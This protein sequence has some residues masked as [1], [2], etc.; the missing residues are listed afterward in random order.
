MICS[1]VLTQE[2]AGRDK[3]AQR[4]NV[5]G[6]RANQHN[7]EDCCTHSLELPPGQVVNPRSPFPLIPIEV[8]KLSAPE[9]AEARQR[10]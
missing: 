2:R 6:R 10:R 1:Q 8:T 9:K 3:E 7:G 5:V 4:H